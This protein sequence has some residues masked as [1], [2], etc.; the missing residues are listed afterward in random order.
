[1]ADITWRD[2][3]LWWPVVLGVGSL[4]FIVGTL[5]Y[6]ILTH[7][8]EID[9]LKRAPKDTAFAENA[10]QRFR[11]LEAN[12]ADAQRI[13]NTNE[14]QHVRINARLEKLEKR[15]E[16]LWTE[17]IELLKSMCHCDD[18]EKE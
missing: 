17:Y 5:Y 9:L 2:Y 18:V 11:A 4:I 16:D 1:M 12:R 10:R 8:R 7:D 13:F 14:E 6:M 3:L 15:L